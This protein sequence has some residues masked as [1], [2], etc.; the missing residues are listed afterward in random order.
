MNVN[1][2]SLCMHQNPATEVNLVHSSSCIVLSIKF[3]LQYYSVYSNGFLLSIVS[4]SAT[5]SFPTLM[6]VK[7]CKLHHWI[8]KIFILYLC[9]LQR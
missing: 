9:T 8:D 3:I 1:L 4:G 6:I 2:F 7:N 5:L